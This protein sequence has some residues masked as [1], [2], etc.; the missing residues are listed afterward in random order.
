MFTRADERESQA[1]YD[2]FWRMPAPNLIFGRFLMGPLGT[3]LINTPLFLLQRRFKISAEQRLLDI[4]C[5]RGAALRFLA[6]RIRLQHPPVGVDFAPAAV[7][8]AHKDARNGPPIDF[9]GAAATRLPF[10]GESFDFILST[11]MVKHLSDLA[12]HRFFYECW[13]VLRPG[14]TLL[15]WEF[16]PVSSTKLN[17]FHHW[18]LSRQIQTCRLRGFGDFVDLAIESPFAN[19]E[20]VNLRPYL[21]PPMPHTAFLLQKATQPRNGGAD[22]GD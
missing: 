12:M 5:G 10:A 3:F 14:G 4:G 15:V 17:R 2:R 13:R 16:A 8:L 6:S 21:F 20:I 18:L 19:M 11:H 22:E 9:V 1:A 7:R